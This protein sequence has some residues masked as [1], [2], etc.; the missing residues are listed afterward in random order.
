MLQFYHGKLFIGAFQF[1]S[2]TKA[3]AQVAKSRINKVNM[4][5]RGKEEMH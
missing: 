4:G 2:E 5:P 3:T 1:H